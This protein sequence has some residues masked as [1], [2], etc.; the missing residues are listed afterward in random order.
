MDLALTD[1]ISSTPT[2]TYSTGSALTVADTPSP[3]WQRSESQLPQYEQRDLKRGQ[4][5]SLLGQPSHVS[6]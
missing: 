1:V 4:Y 3:I 2:G 5:H 6:S